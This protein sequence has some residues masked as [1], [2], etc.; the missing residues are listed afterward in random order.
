MSGVNLLLLDVECIVNRRLR[1]GHSG[2][3]E[4]TFFGNTSEGAGNISS[5]TEV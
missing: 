3:F 4:L 5:L 1:W 2:E